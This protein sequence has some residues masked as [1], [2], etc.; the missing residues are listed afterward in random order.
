MAPPISLQLVT[1][2]AVVI[3]QGRIGE[4]ALHRP[5]SFG[6]EKIVLI[7]NVKNM[8]NFEHF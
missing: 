2:I 5:P 4:G 3:G 8:L 6:G 1:F 7:F